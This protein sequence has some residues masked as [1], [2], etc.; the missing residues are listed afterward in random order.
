MAKITK[1]IIYRDSGERKTRDFQVK[2]YR[3]G[4]GLHIDAASEK[5]SVEFAMKVEYLGR[6][7]LEE[8]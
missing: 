3:N 6:H 5:D 4:S 7:Y 2:G 8:R 1:R